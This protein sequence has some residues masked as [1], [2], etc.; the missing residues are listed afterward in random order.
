MVKTI[1]SNNKLKVCKCKNCNALLTYENEDIKKREIEHIMGNIEEVYY[2]T[3]SNCCKET[4]ICY[5]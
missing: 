3:C 4:I 5:L 1:W 2:I